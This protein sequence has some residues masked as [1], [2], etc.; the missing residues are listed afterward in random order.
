MG[1]ICSMNGGGEKFI[2]SFGCKH[3]ENRWLGDFG[4]EM[5]G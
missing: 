5:G 3:E 2:Q 1:E 4:I